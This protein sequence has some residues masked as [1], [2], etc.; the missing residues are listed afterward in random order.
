MKQ[1]RISKVE[2]VSVHARKV[3]ELAMSPDFRDDRADLHDDLTRAVDS[4]IESW[5]KLLDHLH[6]LGI[7]SARN[8]QVLAVEELD[9]GGVIGDVRAAGTA[10]DS[11]TR[12]SQWKYPGHSRSRRSREPSDFGIVGFQTIKKDFND[13]LDQLARAAKI[14]HDHREILRELAR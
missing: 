8:G 7:E 11:A 13:F 5:E 3:Y 4:L 14:M 6:G 2:A 9:L 10:L 1:I 12:C